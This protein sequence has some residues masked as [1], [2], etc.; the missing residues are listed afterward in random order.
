M[1]SSSSGLHNEAR[2]SR[3]PGNHRRAN[4]E[5]RVVSIKYSLLFRMMV[6]QRSKLASSMLDILGSA[7]SIVL[8]ALCSFQWLNAQCQIAEK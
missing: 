7:V 2:V 5:K 8:L 6:K 4:V 1:R 3:G